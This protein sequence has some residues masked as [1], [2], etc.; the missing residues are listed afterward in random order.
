[1]EDNNWISK[2]RKAHNAKDFS[3][4]KFG[5]ITII[6]YVR[7]NNQ[8]KSVYKWACECGTIRETTLFNIIKGATVSCG[9]KNKENHTS[10]G[11]S[12]DRVYNIWQGV[13]NRTTNP[14]SSQW[15]WY[16]GRGI[17]MCEEW[18]NSFESFFNYVGQPPSLKH[19]IDRYPNNDGHYEPGNVRWATKSEQ[20]FNR[21]KKPPSPPKETIQP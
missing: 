17:A 20:A 3:G 19:S 15:K 12:N 6:E 11:M 16:G 18:L 4:Q 8:R 21:R 13:K 9:C 10:H 7:T 1:M 14:K 2:R 5:S